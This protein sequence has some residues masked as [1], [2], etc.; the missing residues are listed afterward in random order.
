MGIVSST[1]TQEA[2]SA[3]LNKT[4]LFVS[5]TGE[6]EF[7]VSSGVGMTREALVGLRM[8]TQGQE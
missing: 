7:S 6:V 4:M 8:H 2:E 5:H 1:M 3:A